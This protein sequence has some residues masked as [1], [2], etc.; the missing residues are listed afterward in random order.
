M[1]RRSA[2]V[3]GRV[4]LDGQ[5]IYAPDSDVVALRQRVGMVFQ[6]P[7]P[8]PQSVYENV[9]FGPRV[10]G[11]ARKGDLDAVVE[12]SLRGASLWDEVKDDLKMDAQ[13]LSLGQQQRLCIAR[14]IA[15]QAG[16]D[17]DG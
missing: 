6:R 1:T 8:F 4:L 13:R 17:S 11:A 9:A 14:V 2:H 7:N 3:E 16:S 12:Q 5:N 15:R 10:K